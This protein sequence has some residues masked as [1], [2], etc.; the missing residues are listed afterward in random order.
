MRRIR[1]MSI[2][3]SK[4][5]QDL[6][7]V[8]L[9]R[10]SGMVLS[11]SESHLNKRVEMCRGS[12]PLLKSDIVI[13]FEGDGPLGILFIN[14]DN[15]AQVKSISENTVASEFIELRAKMIISNIEGYDCE[16]MSYKDIMNIICSRWKT[17]S[18][19]SIGFDV[20]KVQKSTELNKLCPIY[21]LLEQNECEDFYDSFVDLGVKVEKDLEFIE[22]QD[23]VNM[24]I[25]TQK[26][27]TLNKVLKLNKV[28]LNKSPSLVFSELDDINESSTINPW[29]GLIVDDV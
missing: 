21:L 19:V 22:Y 15:K 25:P 18:N 20:S 24:K 12:T 17:L 4:S 7:G 1:R 2:Q 14:N 26:R 28:N 5:S 8:T 3:K 9:S 16:H 6:S 11:K 29:E 27:R 10:G 13:E 23:L